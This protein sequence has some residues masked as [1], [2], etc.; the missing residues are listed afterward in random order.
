M[1]TGPAPI[2]CHCNQPIELPPDRYKDASGRYA[3]ERC[4]VQMQFP[5]MGKKRMPRNRAERRAWLRER[6]KRDARRR[7]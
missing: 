5:G 2:C 4:A 7:K 3:H 1:S 6:D